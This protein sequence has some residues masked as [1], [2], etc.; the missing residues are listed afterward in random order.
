MRAA[1]SRARHQNDPRRILT[2]PLAPKILRLDSGDLPPLPDDP[3]D[4]YGIR[5]LAAR[6]RFAEDVLAA[7]VATG[8]RQLVVLGAGLDTFAYRNPHA[9]LRVFEVDHPA[10]QVWKRQ[11]LAAA[12]V[13]I[14]SSVTFAP[15]DFER[16]SL[17]GAMASAGLDRDRPVFFF[18]LGVTPYLTRDAVLA[19]LRFMAGHSGPVQVVFD[20]YGEAPSTLSPRLRAVREAAAKLVAELGEPWLTCFTPEDIADELRAMGLDRVDDL[21]GRELIARYIDGP[22]PDADPVGGRVILAGRTTTP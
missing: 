10:T 14:P 11:Q 18:W 4:L 7:A 5:F 13:G 8:T 9:G 20:Y 3:T 2:D 12:G 17:A 19:T 16:D 21:V 6:S 15:V 1:H 22:V